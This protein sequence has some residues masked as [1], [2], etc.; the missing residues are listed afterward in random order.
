MS[1]PRSRRCLS[2]R[3]TPSGAG[4]SSGASPAPT[5]PTPPRTTTGPSCRRW[6][7]RIRR[8]GWWPCATGGPSAGWV[9]VH[10]RSSDG[11]R[12]RARSRSS[13]GMGSGSSTAS[14]SRRR[15]GGAVWR[16]R[17]WTLPSRMPASTEQSPWRVILSRRAER[18]CRPPRR[19]PARPGCSVEPVSRPLPRRAR[20]P[21][22]AGLGSWCAES[23]DAQAGPKTSRHTS[24]PGTMGRTVRP[25]LALVLGPWIHWVR[26]LA[27][28]RAGR[29]VV[30]SGPET[31]PHR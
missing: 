18:A 12:G 19:T 28:S 6:S 17:S 21:R 13:P 22:E 25:K 11:W 5:G 16:V 26:L 2:L 20:R 1:G 10:G 3:Q 9:W 31:V 8:P 30:A 23:C 15:R 27:L 24:S 29:S 4:A 14:W 7:G